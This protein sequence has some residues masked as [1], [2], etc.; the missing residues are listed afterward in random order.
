MT[1]RLAGTVILALT[2]VAV[3]GSKSEAQLPTPS[4]DEAQACLGAAMTDYNKANLVLMQQGTPPLMSVQA[5]I[6]Q[7]RLQE[8]YCFQFVQC[9]NG[10][11][12]SAPFRAAFD[13][14]LRD[15]ALEKYDAVPR[16]E[17]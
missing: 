6:L 5:T 1:K 3:P 2:I 14:C 15:E 11:P 13:S 9:V 12:D 17:E 10:D 8:Q 16:K 7:R 4:T